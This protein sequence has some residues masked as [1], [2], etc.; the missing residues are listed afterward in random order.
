MRIKRYCVIL[1]RP[2]LANGWFMLLIPLYRLKIRFAWLQ[3]FSIPL[4]QRIC[5]CF[6]LMAYCRMR[7]EHVLPGK[8]GDFSI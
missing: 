2:A 7:T 5:G 8:F 3:K 1:S 4:I 6:R